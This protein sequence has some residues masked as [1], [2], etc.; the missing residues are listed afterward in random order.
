M[1]RDIKVSNDEK[2]RVFRM[3][4]LHMDATRSAALFADRV[5]LVEG[6][7]DAILVRQFANA[8]AA[9]QHEPSLAHVVD[10]LT[11]V[12]M[13]SKVGSWPVKL[14]ASHGQEIA[15]KLGILRDSDDRDPQ[16]SPK[17]PAWL[18]RFDDDVVQFFFSEPT[19]E[20]SV[21][22]GNEKAVESALASA[23]LNVPD[24][25]NAASVDKLF[26]DTKSGKGRFAVELAGEIE[27][28]NSKAEAVQI[29]MHFDRM[30]RFLCIDE[31]L[32][33]ESHSD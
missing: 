28:R 7:T 17:A 15:H 6:V 2:A 19:L 30:F 8:W 13:G 3:A 33:D 24:E 22:D 27:R 26:Q 12:P 9:A 29:P 23:G 20:P 31:A 4:K 18:D 14:L 1:L 32:E 10:A 5:L 25:I 16:S 21:V 11:I